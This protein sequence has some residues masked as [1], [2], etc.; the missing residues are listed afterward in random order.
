[1]IEIGIFLVLLAV[2]YGFGSLSERRHYRSIQKREAELNSLPAVASRF[3]AKDKAYE[4]QLV[5]GSVVVAL[6]LIHI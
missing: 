4:Q 6:S 3:P 5:L 2:G 1:M